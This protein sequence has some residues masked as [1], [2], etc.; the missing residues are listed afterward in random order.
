MRK[1][2]ISIL[3]ATGSIGTQALQ[4]LERFPRKF[5]VAALAAKQNLKLLEAQAKK[6]HPRLISVATE[7]AAHQLK[8]RLPPTIKVVFGAD[9]LEQAASLKEADLVLMALSG[10]AGLKPLLAAMEAGKDIALAN[11]EPMVMAGKIITGRARK[12]GVRIIPVDSEHSAIFQLLEGRNRAEIRKV[13][14]SASGGPFREK[15]RR[16]LGKVTVAQALR[17]PTWKMGRKVTIDSATLMNKA[18][19]LIEAKWLFDLEPDQV[20]VIIHPQSLVHSLVEMRDGEIIA[21]LS[22]PDMRIPIAYA[23]FWPERPE[24]DLPRLDLARAGGIKFE[25]PDLRRFPALRLG[26]SALRL[27]G[28]LAAAMNA[29]NEESVSAFLSGKIGFNMIVETVAK[30]MMEHKNLE[31]RNLEEILSAD[32]WARERARELIHV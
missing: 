23:L 3:G 16:E 2:Q 32:G 11:K 25:A 31:A 28:T 22:R 26:F 19:E 14:L 20:E 30:V 10:S 15:T 29:A 9:G 5:Q 24:L 17:H 1:K 7:A 4:I 13:I 27:G 6:F 21:L 18:L 8:K 12:K